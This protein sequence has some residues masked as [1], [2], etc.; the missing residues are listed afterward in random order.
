MVYIALKTR[1]KQEVPWQVLQAMAQ[2]A[3]LLWQQW[4]FCNVEVIIQHIELIKVLLLHP[5]SRFE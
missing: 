4:K 3:Y 5:H 2:V 1:K